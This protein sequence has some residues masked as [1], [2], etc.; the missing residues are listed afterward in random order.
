MKQRHVSFWSILFVAFK[1]ASGVSVWATESSGT[2]KAQSWDQWIASQ[3]VNLSRPV[4]QNRQIS[5][6]GRFQIFGPLLGIS[7]RQDFHTT[8]ILSLAGRFHFNEQF[9][10]EFLRFDFTFPSQTDLAKEIQEQTSFRPDVQLSRFQVGS[11]FVYSPI[12]GK[13]AWNSNEIVYFDIYGKVGGG[14]RFATDQQLFGELG[15][16]MNHYLS[17]SISLVPEIRWR[18]YSEK[19]TESTF[20]AEGLFQLGVAWLL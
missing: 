13:Y 5:K 17:K 14:I 16:G 20:V 12:Y 9:A 2:E 15:V 19:R 8:F 10:W 7:D 6:A 11:S 3:S 1:L 4:V 18:L